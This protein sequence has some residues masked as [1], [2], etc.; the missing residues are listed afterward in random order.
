M[1]CPGFPPARQ[2]NDKE[3][4]A[5]FKDEMMN[6]SV[7]VRVPEGDLRQHAVTTQPDLGQPVDSQEHHEQRII[8]S[9]LHSHG[10]E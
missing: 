10:E 2:V 4:M 5:G 7:S 8:S 9:Y 6:P 3:G 1:S